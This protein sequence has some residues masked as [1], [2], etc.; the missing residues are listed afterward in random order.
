MCLG[1]PAQV[2]E[3]PDLG[4]ARAVVEVGGVRRQVNVALVLPEGLAVGEWVL[5]HV[6][7]AMAKIDE[8]EARRTHELLQVLGQLDEGLEPAVGSPSLGAASALDPPGATAP[9]S[10]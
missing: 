10:G 6:G 8:E 3:A 7:F 4:A 5:V 1:I 9:A 2:V